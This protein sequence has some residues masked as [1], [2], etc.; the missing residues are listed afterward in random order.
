VVVTIDVQKPRT[1]EELVRVLREAAA[2]R[3]AVVPV[4]GGRASGMGGVVERCDV[5]L[6]TGDLDR[7]IEHSPADMVVS[8]EAGITLE[9]LQ[10]ELAS[11]GQFLPIDPFNSP[12]HTVGGLLA[13]G[14]SGPLRLRFGSA[15][16]FLIGIR[17]ALPDGR[18]ASA[19]GRVVKNVSGYDLMKLHYGAMGSL[20]VIVAASFKVFPQPLHDV[21][22]E[23]R[24]ETPAEAWQAAEQVL[25]LPLPPV[26]LEMFSDGRVLARFFGSPAAV[27]MTVS[28]LGWKEADASLWQKHSQ[29]APDR[30]ARI[31]VPRTQLRG[32]LDALPARSTW[33]ASP[34]IGVAHWTF[35]GGEDLSAA[36]SAAEAAGGSLV[37][38]AAPDSVK[39]Q[40]GAWGTTPATL[41]VMRRLK[42]AYD[43][44]HV[45]NPGR[46]VV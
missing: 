8:V 30:W 16:D 21:T 10:A 5:E 45:L 25:D 22:L 1:E 7:V 19:G 26:A 2:A 40:A 27:K 18:L 3:K 29:A 6:R 37:L 36:R 32:I 15:R 9:A 42:D 14:W 31:S 33:W 17:V 11:S 41:E 20:G 35:V 28:G 39:R 44:E 46:F 43:P 13:T 23:S 12:G 34:G 38:M 4:G 24:H